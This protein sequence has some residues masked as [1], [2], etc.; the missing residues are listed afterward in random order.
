MLCPSNAS[1]DDRARAAAVEGGVAA[2]TA[3][4]SV[5]SVTDAL[6]ALA[7]CTPTAD[8]LHEGHVHAVIRR[9]EANADY[10]ANETH[11]SCSRV[12]TLLDSPALYHKRY[13]AKSLAPFS[14]SALEHGTLLHRW[15]EEGDDFLELLVS[16]PQDTLTPTGLLGKEADKWA[17]NEAPEGAVVVAPKERTQ[18]LAEVEAIKANPAAAELLSRVT[19]HEISVYWETLDGHRLKC[20]FDAVTSDGLVLDLKTTREE[21]IL[22]DFH[23]SVLRFR[24]HLQDAW[25]RRGMEAMGLAP[26]PLRFIVI[27]TAIQHDCQV[28]TLPAAVTAAGQ[29]LMDKALAELRL[30]EDLDWWLPDQHGEVVELPFPAHVLGRME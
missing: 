13:I 15:F 20:R 21:D 26:Q 23:G 27:S 22:A 17:K 4:T 5:A 8:G 1:D 7:A 14:S 18:I 6:P 25:Y 29:R 3:D 11:R 16:P 9:G 10:H 19:E 24:Y 28:V 12:K 2:D 30:R